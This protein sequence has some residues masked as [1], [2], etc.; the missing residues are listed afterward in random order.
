MRVRFEIEPFENNETNAVKNKFNLK[1]VDFDI[2]HE[3]ISIKSSKPEVFEHHHHG[4]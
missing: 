1:S 3:K 4:P 2:D